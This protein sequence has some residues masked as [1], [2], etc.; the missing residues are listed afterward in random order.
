MLFGIEFVLKLTD[1][2]LK[3]ETIRASFKPCSRP[4][5]E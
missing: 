3:A 1:N 4:K 5:N 2:A